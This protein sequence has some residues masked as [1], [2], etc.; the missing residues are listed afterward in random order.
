MTGPVA[1]LQILLLYCS[2]ALGEAAGVGME[3]Y[4]L[5]AEAAATVAAAAAAAKW[6]SSIAPMD[7]VVVSQHT[8]CEV[9]NL[10]MDHQR[11]VC[12]MCA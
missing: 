3:G 2:A 9:C 8:R 4:T 6:S 11:C 10:H 5:V 7:A 1:A 12:S